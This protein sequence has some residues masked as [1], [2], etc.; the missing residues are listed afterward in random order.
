MTPSA[1]TSTIARMTFTAAQRIELATLDAIDVLGD[2]AYSTL[3]YLHVVGPFAR[4]NIGEREV[5][6]FSYRAH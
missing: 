1:A 3:I 5:S 4:V 2:V 6:S